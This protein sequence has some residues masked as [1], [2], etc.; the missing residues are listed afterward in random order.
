MQRF[1][2]VEGTSSKFWE[3][4]VTDTDLTV[5]FGRIGTNGQTK[6]KSFA[7]A[8]AASKERDKLVKEKTRGGYTEVGVAAG[9]TLAPVKT[10]ARAATP[11]DV[12]PTPPAVASQAKASP[13]GTSQV[14]APPA[15]SNLQSPAEPVADIEWPTGGFQWTDERRKE[16]PIVRGVH[17]PPLPT[18]PSPLDKR[19]EFEDDRYQFAAGRM[20]AFAT[21]AGRSWTLWGAAGSRERITK[22]ALLEAD[23]EFWLELCAQTAVNYNKHSVDW[24]VNAGCTLHGAAFMLDIVLQLWTITSRASIHH[25]TQM[26]GELRHAIAAA[27]DAQYEAALAVA[28]KA[29]EANV[30]SL[31]PTAYLFPHLSEWAQQCIDRK[32]DDPHM[33][34]P[35]CVL[36]VEILYEYLKS[37]Q[38]YLY[39]LSGP[40]L[41][42]VHLHGERAFDLLV[43]ALQKSSGRDATLQALGLLTAMRTPPLIK[44][45]VDAMENKEVRAALDKTSERYPAAVL[46]VALEKWLAGADRALEGWI[47]RLAI[48]EPEAARNALATLEPAARGKFESLLASL[49][50]PD[51]DP[52]SLPELLRNPPWLQK[53]RAQQLPTLSLQQ[54]PVADAIGW[55]QAESEQ[56]AA[57]KTTTMIYNGAA[58][59]PPTQADLLNALGILPS[60]HQ[61]VLRGEPVRD[62][63]IEKTQHRRFY[64]LENLMALPAPV[65]LS[66][67]NSY[68]AHLWYSW[69]DNREA[70]PVP[71]ILARHGVRALPGFLSFARANIGNGL[72][73]AAKIDSAALA[74]LA[75]HALRN[76]KKAKA[77]A[78]QWVSAHPRTTAI[79]ALPLAFGP[80]REERD[81]ARFGLRWLVHNGFE[82]LARDVAA[83]YGAETTQALQALLEADPL[84][85]LPSKM[86]KVPSFF[87]PASFRRPELPNGSALPLAAMEYIANMLTIS[88]VDAP[89]PGI[90]V[91]RELCTPTSLAEFAWDVFEAWLT[92]GAPSKEGWAFAVLGLFGNDETARRL[93]PRIR[94]W[95]GESAHARAVTGLDILAAIGTDAAL[96]HLNAIASKVKFKGLQDKA[97]EKISAIAEAR[98]LTAAELA[99]RLV[100][101]LGLDDDGKLAL[102][103][104]PRRFY[105]SF[106]ETLKPFVRDAQGTRLKDLPK[107]IKSDDAA[108]AGEATERYKQLK[109]D[110]KAIASVQLIRLELAM[111]ARRRWSAADYKLFFLE[112]PLTRHLAARL[113]WGV[114]RDGRMTNAFR[115]AEDWTLADEQDSLYELPDDAT[116][117]IAHVLE[118]PQSLLTAFGQIFAD[119]EILQPFRQLG[120]ETYTLTADELRTSSLTRYKD[121]T[122]ATGTVMGLIN[123]GWER[124]AAQDA[125]WV[126]W[127]SKA[128]DE[129]HEV[130]LE[131]D[132]GTV[133]GDMS[134]EPKQRLPHVVLR[135]SGTWDHHGQVAFSTLDAVTL[136]E[137]LRDIELMAPLAE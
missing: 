22:Q 92:A 14:Q 18:K 3:V 119:Y 97:R 99:D 24:A 117:G 96:M 123:R 42:Q 48:R 83:E 120:R 32:L 125:G 86:P 121:K 65:I 36:P 90:Q 45:L 17:V 103:F 100:P 72:E 113:V 23:P 118:M 21:A 43:L 82:K 38:F 76:L 84:F 112:H 58:A 95:P 85:V 124:G 130:Q 116:V 132:P 1:E 51:A 133:V 98:G 37:R 106:D 74:E 73:L 66:I 52:A 7:S 16:L 94:E 67:W 40:V 129:R 39:Y 33:L 13:A 46:K 107:P 122:V 6:T 2:L 91:V 5:R 114:Y 126:G 70:G 9:A 60:A 75:L 77:V 31:I 63:D 69:A 93:T 25:G 131:L 111:V 49:H 88:R 44:A 55:S 19:I 102:D 104:G 11:S 135:Q 115:V 79:V 78:T 41:L 87:V 47:V 81:N 68:P 105:V 128:V 108:L 136:S 56:F 34:L 57:F 12:E 62:E 89:Y 101:D 53:R 80:P 110:A 29:R 35:H 127:F 15:I 30:E 109:K 71:A 10:E 8:E 59:S 134:Y 26:F 64:L 50:R 54:L 28:R 137:V 61:R 27:D 4:S 20:Q